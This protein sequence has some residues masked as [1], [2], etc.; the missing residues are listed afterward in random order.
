[1][2]DKRQELR[3][4]IERSFLACDKHLLRMEDAARDMCPNM[5]LTKDVYRELSDED[6]RCMDQFVYRF[7]KFQ[8][9][10][11]AKLF[12]YILEWLQED[13]LSF[14]MIDILNRLERLKIIDDAKEWQYVRELRNAIA[15]DYP[16]DEGEV[17]ESLNELFNHQENL[18][19]IYSRLKEVF[20]RYK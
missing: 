16:L 4:R 1:M 17:I 14:S 12:R 18:Q 6:V 13:V 3:E 10:M 15:H 8:D 11:G 19:K 7:S 9:M 20:E 2:M 5:P